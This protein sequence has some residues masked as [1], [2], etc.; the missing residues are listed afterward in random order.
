MDGSE[1]IACELNSEDGGKVRVSASR[2]SIVS[3][4]CARSL[5]PF[6]HKVVCQPKRLPAE[7]GTPRLERTVEPKLREYNKALL[8]HRWPSPVQ[9]I[10]A[11]VV[12][13]QVAP[14]LHD[15]CNCRS[16]AGW[17]VRVVAEAQKDKERMIA[18]D[19]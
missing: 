11:P 7:L 3:S 10:S 6:L 8:A 13:V 17:H 18:N 14:R 4:A 2:A 16:P 1:T 15:W 5:I 19:G 12:G 9:G